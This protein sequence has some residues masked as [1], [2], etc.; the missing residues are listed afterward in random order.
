[1][2]KEKAGEKKRD[3]EEE[4]A[5]WELAKVEKGDVE[6]VDEEA[7]GKPVAAAWRTRR[8]R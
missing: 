5:T 7:A 1:M 3:L 6:S 2:E 4:T 8:R